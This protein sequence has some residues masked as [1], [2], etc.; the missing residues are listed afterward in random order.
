MTPA[1][2]PATITRE[3]LVEALRLAEQRAARGDG[4]GAALSLKPFDVHEVEGLLNKAELWPVAD[5]LAM[6]PARERRGLRG[7]DKLL[8][9]IRVA[10]LI[11]PEFAR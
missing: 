10:M 9:A 5:L 11:M 4:H 8:R 2:Q 7:N 3:G 6:L 1:A